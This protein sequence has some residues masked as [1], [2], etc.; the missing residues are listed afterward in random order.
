MTVGATC[1]AILAKQQMLTSAIGFYKRAQ[2]QLG[3]GSV[4]AAL[5]ALRDVLLEFH[6]ICCELS[7]ALCELEGSH[8]IVIHLPI[9]RSP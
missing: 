2:L 1:S 6:Q 8:V 3:G 9:E 5:D 7:D 4:V